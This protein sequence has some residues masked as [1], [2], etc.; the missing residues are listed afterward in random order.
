MRWR[1]VADFR[2]ADGIE[3]PLGIGEEVSISRKLEAWCCT[4]T[5][6]EQRTPTFVSPGP[7][8]SKEEALVSEVMSE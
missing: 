1:L 4:C 2:R 3:G 6:S 5:P 8:L 7:W